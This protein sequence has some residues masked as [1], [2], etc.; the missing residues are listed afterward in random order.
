MG[1]FIRTNLFA[2]CLCVYAVCT[3][4][5]VRLSVLAHISLEGDSIEFH[6]NRC[7]KHFPV[8]VAYNLCE[9]TEKS[10]VWNSSLLRRL[11]TIAMVLGKN[12]STKNRYHKV[13]DDGNE[14]LCHEYTDL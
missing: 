9:K 10:C 8:H 14:L 3:C 13:N 5:C 7:V 11:I 12:L 2:K 1:P 6:L 4:K